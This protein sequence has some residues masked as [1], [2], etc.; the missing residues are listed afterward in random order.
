MLLQPIPLAGGRVDLV[1]HLD[2]N[3]GRATVVHHED[4]LQRT[5]SAVKLLEDHDT[6]PEYT[7]SNR[8]AKLYVTEARPQLGLKRPCSH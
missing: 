3:P 1:K 6:K 8:L 2:G 7:R 4:I 5:L